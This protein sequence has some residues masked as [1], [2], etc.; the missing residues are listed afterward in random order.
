[1]LDSSTI[2]AT[3]AILSWYTTNIFTV[4]MNKYLFQMIEFNYPF[5]LTA[6]HMLINTIGSLIALKTFRVVP[7]MPVPQERFFKSIVPLG[8]IFC[9]NIILGNVSLRWIPVSFMQ[10]VKSLVPA[11]TVLLQTVALK[12]YSTK[13]T[14]LSLIPVVGGVGLASFTE[15]NFNAVGFIAALVASL[16]TSIQSIVSS[17]ILTGPLKLD[18]INLLYYMA[19]VSFVFIAPFALY[20]E[21]ETVQLYPFDLYGTNF[22]IACLILSGAVAYLLNI[23]VFFAIKST[24]PLTF[25]VFGNLKVIAVIIISVLIFRNAVTW[26]NA[27]GCVIALIGILWYNAIEWQIKEAKKLAA[28]MAPFQK[29][30]ELQVLVPKSSL[31][32]VDLQAD[33]AE[34]TGDTNEE[35]SV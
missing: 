13:M 17:M 18:S 20:F 12:Q 4:V 33:L 23:C 10:T 7:F 21:Y 16:T 2:T 5:T 24:S 19:P 6:I 11:F 8:A 1:M 30:S 9:L 22:V 27:L 15:Q 29:S 25:T 26:W 32:A 3:I 28:A 31:D 35:K 34:S 14:Y